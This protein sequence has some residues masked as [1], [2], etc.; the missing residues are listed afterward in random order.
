MLRC[1]RTAGQRQGLRHADVPR[2][3][4]RGPARGVY[5]RASPALPPPQIEGFRGTPV[6]QG[7]GQGHGLDCWLS[8]PFFGNHIL[9]Q[10]LDEADPFWMRQGLFLD[11]NTLLT[12][13][14]RGSGPTAGGVSREGPR[15]RDSGPSSSS[16]PSRDSTAAA[17]GATPCWARGP[18]T[19]PP[20][21]QLGEG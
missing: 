6:V 17:S 10:A 2:G 15:N 4:G 18:A 13:Q 20:P 5:G 7:L 12:S 8:L 14:P 1:L 19:P 16:R 21:L 3:P 11:K 9:S